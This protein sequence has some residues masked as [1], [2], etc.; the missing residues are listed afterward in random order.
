MSRLSCSFCVLA[1]KADLKVAAGLRPKLY[2]LI[3][4]IERETDQRAGGG[5]RYAFKNAKSLADLV[6]VNPGCAPSDAALNREVASLGHPR[7]NV[8]AS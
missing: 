8:I 1:S 3:A 2:A 7:L 4:A 6:G 5:K